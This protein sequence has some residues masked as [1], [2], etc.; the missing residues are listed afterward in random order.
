MAFLILS[1]HNIG[2]EISISSKKRCPAPSN[3]LLRRALLEFVHIQS[4]CEKLAASLAMNWL[5]KP[6]PRSSPTPVEKR[7]V[8]I[9]CQWF[10]MHSIADWRFFPA[11]STVTTV[12]R[13]F[14][15][16]VDYTVLLRMVTRCKLFKVLMQFHSSYT[17]IGHLIVEAWIHRSGPSGEDGERLNKDNPCSRQTKKPHSVHITRIELM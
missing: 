11:L 14:A 5:V 4:N 17:T 2:I 12:R 8:C 16:N 10:S 13:A 15:Y 9:H 6:F 7:L 3:P 1:L